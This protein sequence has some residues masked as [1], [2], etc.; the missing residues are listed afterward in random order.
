[1]RED[2]DSSTATGAL[3][4]VLAVVMGLVCGGG[5]LLLAG[6]FFY[7]RAAQISPPVPTAPPAAAP[8]QAAAADVL[9]IQADGTFMWN[10]ELVVP[11]E[12]RTRL[13]EANDSGDLPRPV[14]LRIDE[15]APAAAR[16][17][18]LQL[19]SDRA[20]AYILMEDGS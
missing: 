9:T 1:M 13:D 5:A 7:V 3:V 11:P 6:T 10:D 12:L 8:V 16:D 17:E 2:R 15:A 19:L 20:V 18:I 4:A 14:V